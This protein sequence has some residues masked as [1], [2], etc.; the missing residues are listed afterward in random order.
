[1]GSAIGPEGAV[2]GGI[3]GGLTGLYRGI[4]AIFDHK[5]NPSQPLDDKGP[6]GAEVLQHFTT[7]QG[8]SPYNFLSE[9]A[10]QLIGPR[11]QTFL[12]VLRS[13]SLSSSSLQAGLRAAGIVE[14]DPAPTMA[15]GAM[16]GL[17]NRN[18]V[19]RNLP[20]TSPALRQVI[21]EG[22]SEGGAA[23]PSAATA[24][25]VA[26]SS[27]AAAH[28]LSCRSEVAVAVSPWQAVAALL[29]LA[30]TKTSS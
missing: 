19:A 18:S 11:A 16:Q 17:I 23:L 10:Q 1:M 9:Q 5:S 13:G 29:T 15:H 3:L 22:G 20:F 4:A 8:S 7:G 28:S 26:Q 14:G 2:G 12:D 25:R 24:V 27:L 6:S 30:H 21:A